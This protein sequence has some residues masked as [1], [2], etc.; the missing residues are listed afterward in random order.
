MYIGYVISE[1]EYSQRLAETESVEQRL[2]VMNKYAWDIRRSYPLRSLEIGKAVK[3]IAL[4][5]HDDKALAF[6]YSNTGTAY[7][8]LSMYQDSLTELMIARSMFS[9][10]KMETELSNVIRTIGNIFHSI[11][12]ND[13]A[14]EEYRLALEIVERTGD[15]IGKAYNLGNIG[16]VLQK[17]GEL[18]ESKH[19]M[20]KAINMMLKEED[21]VGLSDALNILGNIHLRE[22]AIESAY[23]EFLKA[24]YI[25][26]KANHVRGMA[27]A[28]M[29]MGSY[30]LAK[31]SKDEAI[32]E[33][34]KALN[35]ANTMGEKMLIAEIQLQLSRLFEKFKDTEKALEYYKDYERIKTQIFEGVK[36][37][38]ISATISNEK[39][40]QSQRE[41]EEILRRAEELK[42]AY[43]QIEEKN[44]ELEKLSMV[45][46][47]MNE[48]VLIADANGKIEYIN[49][50][51]I[52]NSGYDQDEF[53]QKYGDVLTLQQMSSQ[54]RI[55]EIVRGFQT[56]PEVVQ[57]DSSHIRKDG[58]IMWTSGSLSPV[59]KDNKL[60]KIVVVYTDITQRKGYAD[61]LKR[62]NRNIVD[63]L[64][65]A[66]TI[67]EAILPNKM[68]F[69]E[70]FED[71]FV[72]YQPRDIVSGDFYWLDTRGSHLIFSVVDCTGHGVPGGFM[73]MMGNDYITQIITDNQVNSPAEA[74]SL[75]N[76]RIQIALKQTEDSESRDGMD[77]ALCAVDT[78]SLQMEYAGAN[79]PVYIIRKGRIIILEPTK[80]SIAGGGRTTDKTFELQLF[81]LQK[82][83][84]VYLFS[85]GY[86]DQFGG[87]RRKKMG[88][89]RFRELLLKNSTL[90]MEK[91][92][93]KLIKFFNQ[94]RGDIKQIDDICIL[95]LRF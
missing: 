24:Y 41:K 8:L 46:S 88:Y 21:D 16:Y 42:E 61:R 69:V 62:T 87:D 19:Y 31:D 53:Y 32:Q 29:H 52:R 74:L 64:N 93:Q 86:M 56:N 85:D 6:G 70:S 1:E 65:Y 49:Y 59:Y 48:A 17:K 50:G 76:R 22:G 40:K 33:Y 45:A 18:K 57:Y 39:L 67:Q 14:I 91:Q 75:L 95:G 47:K 20:V 10:L 3:E 43:R 27:N 51:F 30:Y 55:D 80:E 28:K 12:E 7:Y 83:D 79:N 25:A 9:E 60:H 77:L 94:W 26:S 11:N 71:Y 4:E 90:P 89:K 78:H 73:S 66:R 38:E 81:Q 58:T 15:R 5:Q 34:E 92:K 44:R 2:N 63:S 13:K 37:N 54:K 35:Y 72:L 23:K 36:Q 68:R 82:G 84:Q